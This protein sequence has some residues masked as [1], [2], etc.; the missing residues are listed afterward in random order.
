MKEKTK[1]DQKKIK[2]IRTFFIFFYSLAGHSPGGGTRGEKKVIYI[3]LYAQK[4]YI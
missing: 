2:K 4:I 1:R 3:Y